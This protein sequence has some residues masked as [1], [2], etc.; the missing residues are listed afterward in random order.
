MIRE[1][2]LFMGLGAVWDWDGSDESL[3]VPRRGQGAQFFGCA[4]KGVLKTVRLGHFFQC[5]T[6]H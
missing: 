3:K 1:A 6:V 4:G 2:S 5:N